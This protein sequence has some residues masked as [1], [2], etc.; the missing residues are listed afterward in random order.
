MNAEL[1]EPVLAAVASQWQQLFGAGMSDKLAATQAALSAVVGGFDARFQ[2][3]FAGGAG[4][5]GTAADAT[6][7]PAAQRP[8]VSAGA[9]GAILRAV[10]TRMRA[11]G[12]QLKA[13]VAKQQQ[14]ISRALEP[15][16]QASMG[17]GY[18]AGAAEAGTGSHARR[19]E[20]IDGHVRTVGSGEFRKAAEG[21]VAKLLELQARL[22][23]ALAKEASEAIL[24]DLRVRARRGRRPPPR[25]HGARARAQNGANL[26]GGFGAVCGCSGRALGALRRCATLS[27]GGGGVQFAHTPTGL[28]APSCSVPCP[29]LFA[30]A[31]A[32]E[33]ARR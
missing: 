15:A 5:V 24:T 22:V 9:H 17:P 7:A 32:F 6:D 19:K 28:S 11:A 8:A 25:L 13:E 16:V 21:L 4:G 14:E 18:A 23:G 10:E 12:D 26:G 2:Q 27:R 20:I 31:C 1:A 3:A 33:S 29:A 30:L